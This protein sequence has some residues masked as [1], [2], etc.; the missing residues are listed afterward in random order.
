MTVAFLVTAKSGDPKYQPLFRH[1]MR[2]SFCPQKFASLHPR[3]PQPTWEELCWLHL[4]NHPASPGLF[5]VGCGFILP[6]WNG[7]AKST[8]AKLKRKGNM[9]ASH[10]SPSLLSLRYQGMAEVRASCSLSWPISGFEGVGEESWKEMKEVV[11][12]MENRRLFQSQW[13]ARKK[14]KA[15]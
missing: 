9:S 12:Q 4:V 8:A 6:V 10:L 14:C 11:E 7:W 3:S 5:S 13:V 2:D 15:K 1:I